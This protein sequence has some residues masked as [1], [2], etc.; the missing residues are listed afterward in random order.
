MIREKLSAVNW[1][2]FARNFSQRSPRDKEHEGEEGNIFALPLEK[3]RCFRYCYNMEAVFRL[4]TKEL[5]NSFINSIKDAYPNRNIEITV[6]EQDETEYLCRSPANLE[7]L[8]TAI[9]NVNQG[10]IISFK[11][12]E[13]AVQC[14]EGRTVAN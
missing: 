13:Q 6:R 9:E 8:E 4:N 2:L 7:H 5:E 12:L 3:I 14:A 10:K 1:H 11:T